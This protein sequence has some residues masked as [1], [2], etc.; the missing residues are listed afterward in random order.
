MVSSED[1]TDADAQFAEM[2]LRTLIRNW[3]VGGQMGEVEINT[4]NIDQIAEQIA[5]AISNLDD[6]QLL[7]DYSEDLLEDALAAEKDKR[8]RVAIL[9]YATFIEHKING[10][11]DALVRR[12]G[13][14]A[15]VAIDIIRQMPIQQKLT[16]VLE[17]LGV[18]PFG[19]VERN[20]INEIMNRRNEFV[21]YKWKPNDESSDDALVEVISKCH[22]VAEILDEYQDRHI[23]A[24]RREQTEE[25]LRSAWEPL[26]R[27]VGHFLSIRNTRKDGVIAK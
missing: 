23:Y 3:L 17:L 25:L 9:L 5:L 16:S 10:F 13:L 8:I 14:S 22:K 15:Q 18:P 12:K 2:L 4:S 11:I 20:A 7:T 6:N 19:K 26:A 21:H 27:R 1:G 24:N